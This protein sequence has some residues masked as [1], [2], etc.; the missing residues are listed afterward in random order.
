MTIV[1]YS[2]NF[3]FVKTKKTAGTS[4]EVFLAR[5]CGK[6]DVITPIVPPNPDH[7]P[8]NFQRLFGKSFENHMDAV[9]IRAL[10]KRD[11]FDRAFKFCFERHPV[12]KSISQFAML[13]NSP[14]HQ[15]EGRPETWDEYVE[16]GNF[17]TNH[18]MYTDSS[19][20]LLV[21]RVFKYEEMGQALVEIGERCGVSLAKLDVW[22]KSGFR[23]NVPTLEEVRANPSQYRRIMDAF[24]ET[25]KH[26]S[27]D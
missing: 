19:G 26:V 21:D 4:L 20:A 22:E 11:F 8:Q 12:D 16:R 7:K 24:N 1:S 14:A 18:Q 25:L 10:V 13:L 9:D 17:P 15:R 2:R 3:I 6:E 5:I 27:Y 23:K